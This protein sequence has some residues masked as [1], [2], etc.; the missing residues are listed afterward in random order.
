MKTTVRAFTSSSQELTCESAGSLP[1]A[2]ALFGQCEGSHFPS[3]ETSMHSVQDPA[4]RRELH[5]GLRVC[6]L[7]LKAGVFVQTVA[8]HG[9]RAL[10]ALCSIVK[11]GSRGR[12]VSSSYSLLMDLARRRATEKRAEGGE[13]TAGRMPPCERR[14]GSHVCW[15]E[16][17]G[18][19]RGVRRYP[20]AG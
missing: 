15:W 14:R 6:S 8:H 1:W 12:S 3:S 13:T 17:Q 20:R 9:R 19:M 16:S 7:T 4:N 5:G 10:P 11:E 18:I 2:R